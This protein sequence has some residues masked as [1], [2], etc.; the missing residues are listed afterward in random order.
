MVRCKYVIKAYK[1]YNVLDNV[2]EMSKYFLKRLKSV[3]YLKNIRNCGLLFAFDFDSKSIRDKF[4]NC[5][6]KNKMLC[7]PTRERTVRLR[8]NLCVTK[9]EIDY[10][11]S[12]IQK[13]INSIESRYHSA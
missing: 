4:V 7:N 8:P 9:D 13:S 1:D 10:A 2:N 5:L 6:W 11:L 12:L 3:N